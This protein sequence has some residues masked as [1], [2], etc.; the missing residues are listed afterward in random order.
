MANTAKK[1]PE[2]I[3]GHYYVDTSCI[4]CELCTKTAPNNFKEINEMGWAAIFKQ[5]ENPEE[6]Q[7][8]R[9]AME[10]CPTQS[11]GDDGN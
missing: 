4:Y 9:E 11:I 5:P 6:E 7:A 3:N 8:C 10:G 2:N 1:V